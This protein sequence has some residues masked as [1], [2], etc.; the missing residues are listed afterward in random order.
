VSVQQ[1]IN[2]TIIQK[3]SRMKIIKTAF[4]IGLILVASTALAER[5]EKDLNGA[6]KSGSE[7]SEV[8]EFDLVILN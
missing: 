3:G 7:V 5:K 8:T 4:A 2:Q 6:E 1:P